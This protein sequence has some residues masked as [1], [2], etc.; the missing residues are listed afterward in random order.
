MFFYFYKKTKNVFYIYG[1]Y[2]TRV[3]VCRLSVR[4]S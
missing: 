3:V 1:L 4:L 2:M